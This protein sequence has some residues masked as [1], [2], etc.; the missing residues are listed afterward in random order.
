MA[1]AG[2][3]HHGRLLVGVDLHRHIAADMAASTSLPE[4]GQWQAW[5]DARAV[6][7]NLGGAAKAE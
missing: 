4:T 7:Q 2:V 6:K 1:P 5:A 3:A